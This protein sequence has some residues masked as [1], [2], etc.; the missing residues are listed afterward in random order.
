MSEAPLWEPSDERRERATITRYARWLRDE[1][2]AEID[3]DDYNALWQWSVDE[4]EAF[5]A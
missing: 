1:R 3:P 2:G 5:W 4:L